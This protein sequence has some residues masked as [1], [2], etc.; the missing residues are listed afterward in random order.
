MTPPDPD[1]QIEIG[2]GQLNGLLGSGAVPLRLI[3]CREP[4]EWQLCR[5]DG[6]ELVPLSELPAKSAG[7]DPAAEE[8]L[9]V[10][11]HLGMRSLQ[12]SQFLRARGFAKTFS[13][14]GGIDAWSTEIDPSVP[15]Y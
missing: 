11:C 13:L 15:R 14:A 10:Y 8:H 5:I 9:V 4:D 2:A 3:D 7:W 1:G 12:A 6:A